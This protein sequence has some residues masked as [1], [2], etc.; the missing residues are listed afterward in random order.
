MTGSNLERYNQN[1]PP[2]YLDCNSATVSAC[3][4]STFNSRMEQKCG[5]SEHKSTISVASI[6]RLLIMITSGCMQSTVLVSHVFRLLEKAI[7]H[8][9]PVPWVLLENV[10]CLCHTA[11]FFLFMKITDFIT[12]LAA[13]LSLKRLQPYSLIDDFWIR[14]VL[15]P[16]CWCILTQTKLKFWSN[17]LAKP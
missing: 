8:N 12:L 9:R 1:E 4:L 6:T 7:S 14:L 16:E 17:V 2:G 13:P 10:I 5:T 11:A 3:S 15:G